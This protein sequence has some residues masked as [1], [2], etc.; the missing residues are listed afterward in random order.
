MAVF[1]DGTPRQELVEVIRQVRSRWRTRMLLRGGGHRPRRGAGGPGARLVRAADLQVQPG[2]GHWFPGRD[3]RHVCRAARAV[4]GPPAGPAR[5][6]PAGRALRRGARAVAAGRDSERRRH[7]R[8]VRRPARSTSRRSIVDK[9]VA[10]AVEKARA[11]DGGRTVGRARMKRQRGRARRRLP[12]SA[13]C[14]SIVGPEFL[15]QGA[16][17]LLDADAGRGGQP[18]RHQG[19]ARRRRRCRRARTRRWRRS[20]PASDRTTSR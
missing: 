8:R 15:R 17:A 13:R 5:Q 12:G 10:Q 1:G 7:R 9:L 16:S 3:L 14:C 2:V 18:V 19:D 6:R 20:S 11:I 4:A